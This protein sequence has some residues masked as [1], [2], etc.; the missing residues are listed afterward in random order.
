[1]IALIIKRITVIFM[2]LISLFNANSTGKYADYCG[3][4]DFP[5]YA[6]LIQD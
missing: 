2:A 6:D 3:D 4:Y 5:I 1:M